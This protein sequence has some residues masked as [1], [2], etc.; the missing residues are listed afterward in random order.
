MTFVTFSALVLGLACGFGAAIYVLVGTWHFRYN[1]KHVGALY[2]VLALTYVSSVVI[3]IGRFLGFFTELPRG[4]TL[5][6]LAPILGIPPGI[7]WFSWLRARR[8]IR[9]SRG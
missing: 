1:T 4:T 7:Q 8:L 2:Y 5:A 9:E 3:V 6:I